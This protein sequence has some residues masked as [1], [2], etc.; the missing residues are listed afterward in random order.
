M[1]QPAM[2]PSAAAE[3]DARSAF[4]ALM[5]ACGEHQPLSLAGDAIPAQGDV[6]LTIDWDDVT[7]VIS[8]SDARLPGLMRVVCRWGPLPADRAE[9]A[10]RRLLTI[11]RELVPGA[12]VTLGLDPQTGE[13][14]Q[15]QVLPVAGLCVAQLV[16]ELQV[17]FSRAIEWRHTA[18]LDEAEPG[19][20]TRT[21]PPL[22]M[23]SS[24]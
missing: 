1:T 19:R 14:C 8:H 23:S 2:P 17:M 11:Q 12:S 20:G 3:T 5:Q 21:T 13:V 22:P 4:A 15:T 6:E 7:F 24:I 9:A 18:F 10:M 16:D